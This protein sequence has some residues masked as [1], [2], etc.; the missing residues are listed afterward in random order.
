ML[1]AFRTTFATID[2]WQR[3]PSRQLNELAAIHNRL[4][5]LEDLKIGGRS[6]V[7]ATRETLPE[8]PFL[9]TCVELARKHRPV[10]KD[11]HGAA[12]DRNAWELQIRQMFRGLLLVHKNYETA[13]KGQELA[14]RY[15]DQWFE[16]LVAP[17]LG[18]NSQLTRSM[19]V[20]LQIPRVLNAQI[21]LF[22]GRE[23]LVSHWLEF[24]EKSLS[25][26]RELGLM[27]YEN[28]EA[29]YRSFQPGP[30][31]PAAPA[32]PSHP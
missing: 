2:G 4:P 30:G 3:N 23:K 5:R 1:D 27:P 8:E 16:Q 19:N 12:D 20:S 29:F 17:P 11:D 31:G 9:A 15:A 21:K 14:L 26:Y 13:R 25:L 32:A 24:K 10:L 6:L 18:G 28:W 7:E 22:G